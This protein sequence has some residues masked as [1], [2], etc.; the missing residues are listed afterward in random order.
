VAHRR[1]RLVAGA[2]ASAVAA[3]LFASLAGCGGGGPTQLTDPDDIPPTRR[4]VA[5]DVS[6]C[7]LVPLAEASSAVDVPLSVVGLEYGPSRVPTARCLLGD[8]FGV[9]RLTVELAA[10]PVASNVFVEAYGDRAGGDPE[11]VRRL[12]AI[13]YLRNEKDESS[14][15]VFVRG[16]IVSLLLVRDPAQPVQRKELLDLARGVV[17]RLPRN[18]RLAA[19]SA[20]PACSGLPSRVVGAVIG[21][22]P[23]RAVGDLAADGSLTCSWGS[24]PGSV[25]VTVIRDADRVAGYRKTLDAGSYVAVRGVGPG[26]TALSR[27]SEAGDLTLFR[28][29]GATAAMAI[30]SVVPSAGYPD[31]SIVTTPAEVALA[32]QVARTLM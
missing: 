19:T 16:S 24:F 6:V 21:I 31:G 28:R 13:A 30:V 14:L 29:R 18:P 20:G 17:D 11:P 26:V 23:S 22:E 2:A 27:T 8:E 15:H 12:G 4:G 25:D 9:A 7:D 32:R 10:G 1:R 5:T 3:T